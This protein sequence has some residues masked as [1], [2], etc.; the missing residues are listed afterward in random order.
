[1]IHRAAQNKLMFVGWSTNALGALAVLAIGVSAY[2]AYGWLGSEREMIEARRRDD[3]ALMARA[4]QVRAEHETA[5][6]YLASLNAQLTDLKNRLPSSPQEAE[7]LAQLSRLA[8]HTGVR[9]KNFRPGQVANA[10]SVNTCE[11]QLSLVGQF[12]SICKLF[13]GLAD[14]PRFLHVARVTLAGPQSASDACTA[15]VTINL[16]FAAAATKQ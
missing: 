16:C 15:E 9:L 10:G 5:T 11:V 4:E 1:M 14:V 6:S 7:F 8:E 3:L 2:Q 12:A 13:G